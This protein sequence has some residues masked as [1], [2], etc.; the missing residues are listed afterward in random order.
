MTP[1]I[2]MLLA[3]LVAMVYLFLTE[4]LP[5]DLTAF[6]GLVFLLFAGYLEPAEAFTGFS[7]TAVITMLAWPTWRD[8]VCTRWSA[9]RRCRS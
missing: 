7:S 5:I 9:A 8:A 1:E 3:V 2:G 6:L 4:R